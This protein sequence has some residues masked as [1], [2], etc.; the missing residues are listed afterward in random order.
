LIEQH[1]H[2]ASGNLAAQ[3]AQVLGGTE[4]NPTHSRR[5]P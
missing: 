2:N 1:S 4:R 3:L 5:Q